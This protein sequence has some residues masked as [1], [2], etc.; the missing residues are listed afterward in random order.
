M[1]KFVDMNAL[2][3]LSNSKVP[4]LDSSGFLISQDATHLT[5]KGAEFLGKKI[6]E[7]VR[8]GFIR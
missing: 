4:I 3:G 1:E 6:E 7:P 5:P 2:I 8:F